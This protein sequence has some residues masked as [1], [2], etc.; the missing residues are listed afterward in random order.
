[1]L[2]SKHNLHLLSR[3][4]GVDMSKL[5]FKFKEGWKFFDSSWKFVSSPSTPAV[6]SGPLCGLDSL[7][8][9]RNSRRNSLGCHVF[10]ITANR[11]AVSFGLQVGEAQNE[12]RLFPDRLT[13]F[14]SRC[15]WEI[16]KVTLE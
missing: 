11:L 9:G 15:H 10:S 16:M 7:T 14:A 5:N 3:A 1:M 13:P 8:V 12:Y 6:V 4:D 2:P